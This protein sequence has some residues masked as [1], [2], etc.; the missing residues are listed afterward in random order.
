VKS[1]DWK[2]AAV[3]LVKQ[4]VDFVNEFPKMIEKMILS[5]K[6]EKTDQ[7]KEILSWETTPKILDYLNQEISGVTDSFITE[8]QLNTWVDHVKKQLGI[9]GKQLFM[10]VRAAL[11]GQDHGPELKI[12][13]PL[14]P[15]S[16]IK[17]RIAQLKG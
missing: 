10:G 3:E 4:Y 12:L 8:A 11:T 15:V 9:K 1:Q 5:E 7:L 16:V 6:I 13:I 2:K 17:T 14:T